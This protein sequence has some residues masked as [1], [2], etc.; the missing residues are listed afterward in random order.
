MKFNKIEMPEAMYNSKIEERAR[1]QEMIVQFTADM[2]AAR[3]LGDL[4]ENSEYAGAKAALSNAQMRLAALNDELAN[5]V[6]V[7]A[8]VGPKIGIGD[9]VVVTMVDKDHNSI[10]EPREFTI[11]PSGDT[12]LKKVLST[13]SSLGRLICGGVSGYYTIPDYG[14]ISYYVEKVRE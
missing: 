10:S 6:K 14:G 5:A 7:K 9:K 11:A 3:E 2:Q 12:V 8:S 4:K 13:K 1:L